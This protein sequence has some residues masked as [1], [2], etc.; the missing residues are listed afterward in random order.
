MGSLKACWILWLFLLWNDCCQAQDIHFTQFWDPNSFN[1]PSMIGS[2]DGTLRVCGMYR[3]QWSQFNTSLKSTFVEA[4]FKVPVKENYF[5][6]GA[7]FF[8]DKLEFLGYNQNRVFGTLMYQLQ[9]ARDISIGLGFQGGMRMTAMDYSKLTFDKQWEPNSG[10]FD[11]ANPSFERYDGQT[12]MTPILNLG[13]NINLVNK[14]VLH[15]LDIGVSNINTPHDFYY[16]SNSSIPMKF[17]LNYHNYINIKEQ[18]TL[19]PKATLL[20]SSAA[21]SFL[22]GLLVKMKLTNYQYLY[23]GCM[24]RWGVDRNADAL[25]PTVGYKLNA[26]KIGFSYDYNYSGISKESVKNALE[27]SVVY[28]LAPPKNKYFSIDCLRL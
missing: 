12:V 10:T 26:I 11:P 18:W 25:T 4:N 15:T 17:V 14:K 27:V 3:T 16:K 7:S 13:G 1:N 6:F 24:V 19:M 21:N 20:Y 28:I 8:N 2:F 22:T 23:G 9:V 5:S